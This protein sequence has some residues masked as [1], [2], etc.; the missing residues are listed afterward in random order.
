MTVL[1]WNLL[2]SSKVHFSAALVSFPDGNNGTEGFSAVK[3]VIDFSFHD[4]DGF[5]RLVQLALEA[6]Y[7]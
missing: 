4:I 2:E 3:R 1:A 6:I 5:L 7:H